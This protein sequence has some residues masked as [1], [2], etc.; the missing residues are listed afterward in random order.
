M[1]SGAPHPKRSPIASHYF[2][3]RV[4]VTLVG[5]G[6]FLGLLIAGAQVR[7]GQETLRAAALVWFFGF[8]V[9]R[10]ALDLHASR[11]SARRDALPGRDHQ[12]TAA[13]LR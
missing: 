11:D 6:G 10:V 8:G 12:W 2:G 4:I 1:G 5:L 3:A 13:G 9:V 7:S